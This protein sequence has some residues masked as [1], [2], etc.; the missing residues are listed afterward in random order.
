MTIMH[1]LLRLCRAD[2]HGV[3]DQLED[4]RLLLK[5]YLREMEAELDGKQRQLAAM[6]ARLEHLRTRVR[7]HTDEMPRL[8]ADLEQALIRERDDIARGLIRRRR[9]LEATVRHLD[10]Q[11]V[12]TTREKTHLAE[13]IDHQQLQY[14]TLK[15]GTDAY[16]R[17]PAADVFDKAAAA[18]PDARTDADAGDEAVELELLQR[19]DALRK[20]ETP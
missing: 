1:R 10:A 5:Q 17:G 12:E 13:L 6:S 8:E 9:S 2:V 18:F 14:E 11:I 7:R 20:G 15:S 3:M 19:K 16:C 4:K